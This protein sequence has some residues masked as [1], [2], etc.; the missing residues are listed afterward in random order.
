MVAI[1]AKS[2]D[3]VIELFNAFAAEIRSEYAVTDPAVNAVAEPVA[4]EKNA[5]PTGVAKRL[6]AAL[7]AAPHGV[8]AMSE[9]LKGL[10]ETSSN[11]AS[12]KMGKGNTIRIGS[13]QRSSINS[14]RRFA[15]D[16]FAAVFRLAGAQVAHESEYPGW[17]PNEFS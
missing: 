7:V 12:V 3:A 4:R 15:G 13:S 1:P 9:E 17:K 5:I 8:L 11:L 14:A 2:E 16:R 6:V 10:V